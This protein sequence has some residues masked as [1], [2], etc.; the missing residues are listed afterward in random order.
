MMN[1]HVLQTAHMKS[2]SKLT[3]LLLSVTHTLPVPMGYNHILTFPFLE[4]F[5]TDLMPCLYTFRH[6]Y[7]IHKKT[8]TASDTLLLQSIKRHC[9]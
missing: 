2:Y 3:V 4:I 9:T 8:K 7:K 1:S 5:T 6:L